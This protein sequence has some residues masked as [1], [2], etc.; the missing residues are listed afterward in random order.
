MSYWQ[1]LQAKLKTSGPKPIYTWVSDNGRIEL[2]VVTFANAVSKASNFISEGLELDPGTRVKV[3]LGNHWQSPVWAAAAFSTN[4][5]LVTQES[6]VTFGSIEN[7]ATKSTG[8][9]QFVVVSKDP[10]GMPEKQIPEGAING[11]LEVRSYGDYFAP[12]EVMPADTEVFTNW[13]N[14]YTWEQ[15]SELAKELASSQGLNPG[16][17]FGIFGTPDELTSLLLQVVLPVQ[18]DHSVVLIDQ[19]DPDFEAVTSQEKLSFIFK[20]Q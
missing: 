11:S 7:E 16:S 9:A 1:N 17:R 19:M 10:F 6:E 4:L 3:A 12:V 18:E 14:G 15:L 20:F 5:Q 8:G 13:E 2:S